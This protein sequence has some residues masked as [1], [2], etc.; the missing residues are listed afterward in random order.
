MRR[1]ACLSA[2]IALCAWPVAAG[3]QGLLNSPQIAPPTVPQTQT[4]TKAPTSNGGGGLNTAETIGLFAFGIGLI[5]VIAV[6]I[7]SDARSKAPVAEQEDLGGETASL[8][9]H[10][11]VK[12]KRRAQGREAKAQRKKN[13]PR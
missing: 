12:A 11:Q 4:V 9:R 6:I 3:A 7:V 10:R 1:L 5:A 13:R 8:H 2:V